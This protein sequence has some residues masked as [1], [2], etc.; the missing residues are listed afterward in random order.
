MRCAARSTTDPHSPGR[1]RVL[2]PV[3]NVEAWY[4]AFGIN[5]DDAD[6]HPAGAAR[7]H[8][9]EPER[10]EMEGSRCEAAPLLDALAC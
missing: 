5:P 10:D 6:V 3:Q 2:G 8:L 9:V 4:D 1:F 7:A